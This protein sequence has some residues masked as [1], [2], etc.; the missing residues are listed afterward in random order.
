MNL[1]IAYCT[2]IDAGVIAIEE[3]RLNIK[4]AMNGAVK[5]TLDR[6]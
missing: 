4:Y 6:F 2:N 3:D 5:S 1:T